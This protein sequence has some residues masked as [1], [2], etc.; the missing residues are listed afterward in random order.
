MIMYSGHSYRSTEAE[1]LLEEDYISN[2]ETTTGSSF[3]SVSNGNGLRSTRLKTLLP[4]LVHGL[5]LITCLTLLFC[6]ISIRSKLPQNC[7]TK[8]NSYS[9]I[10]EAVNENDF[11]DTDFIYS[12]W[13]KSP[14]KGPPTPAVHEAW[15]SIMRYGEFSVPGSEILRVGHNLTAVQF[16]AAISGHEGEYPVFASGT[17]G[18]HCLH[19]IWQD[20]HISVL[21][22][23]SKLKSDI[24]EMYERHYE[25]CVDYIRQYIMCKFDTT[26]IPFYWVRTHNTPTPGGNTVH[27]CV[28]WDSV[29][30][31][32]KD[33]VVEKPEGFIWRQPADAVVLDENP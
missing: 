16:P 17:H 29:Q 13:Y 10:L 15:M 8:L 27:K 30:S 14:F 33:R 12:L 26:I 1:K 23:V 5:S 19:Y 9:P 25:H 11:Q 31:W 6:T 24:P 4:W 21:P 20:H 22:E 7:I 3:P 28:N 32:L 18:I 2:E